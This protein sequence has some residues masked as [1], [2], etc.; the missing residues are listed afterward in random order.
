MKS[1][2]LCVLLLVGCTHD[3]SK[4]GNTTA[5]YC[6]VGS[7]TYVDDSVYATRKEVAPK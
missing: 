4:S 3:L 2:A 5:T 1:L 7:M 6:L